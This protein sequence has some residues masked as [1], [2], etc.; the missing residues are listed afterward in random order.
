MLNIIRQVNN[1]CGAGR[2]AKTITKAKLLKLLCYL[3]AMAEGENLDLNRL[4]IL[5]SIQA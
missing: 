4:L 1:I 2:G 5:K 3:K